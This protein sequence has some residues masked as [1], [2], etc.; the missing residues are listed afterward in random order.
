MKEIKVKIKM[1]DK[2][3]K[4]PF[5]AYESAAGFDLYSIEE[6]IIEPGKIAVVGTGVAMEIEPGY[7]FQFWDRSGFGAKGIH[8]FAGL[9][10]SDYR[11]EFKVVLFNSTD[12]A[13]KI[14]KGERIVQAVPVKIAKANFEQVSELS[15]T[16]RGS[17]GFNST[18]K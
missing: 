14:E 5:Y 13:F 16:K 11:G 6:K 18:G 10:D 15:E 12:K 17:G 7:C 2:D 4:M 1:L 9:I 3:A 8:H